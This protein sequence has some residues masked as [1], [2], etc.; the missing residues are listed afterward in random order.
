MPAQIADHLLRPILEEG[1][2]KSWTAEQI[3]EKVLEL[4]QQT[5]SISTIR[6]RQKEWGMTREK[7]YSSETLAPM[8]NNLFDQPWTQKRMLIDLKNTQDIKISQ[9]TLAR[10]LR[11]LGLSRKQDD[12][13][14]GKVSIPEAFEKVE[15]L[16]AHYGPRLG[17]KGMKQKLVSDMGTH[18]H[19]LVFVFH[20]YLIWTLADWKYLL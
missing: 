2:E 16:Q 10:Q 17:V 5:V 9:S 4:H 20:S 15:Q 6:R 11:G 7:N 13:D 12:I 18:L 14:Q 19:R 8:L 3:K 1:F